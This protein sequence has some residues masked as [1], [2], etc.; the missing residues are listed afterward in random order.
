MKKKTLNYVAAFVAGVMLTGWA[1]TSRDDS[2]REAAAAAARS[3]LPGV[4]VTALAKADAVLG[5][6]AERASA[7]GQNV[8][9]SAKR[10]TVALTEYRAARDA[11]KAVS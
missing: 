9:L 8:S 5:F 7:S 3:D 4:C 2:G 1:F 11:C 6:A 10:Y